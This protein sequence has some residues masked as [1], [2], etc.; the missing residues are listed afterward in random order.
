MFGVRRL[1]PFHT[2]SRKPSDRRESGYRGIFTRRSVKKHPSINTI[3]HLQRA[4][5]PR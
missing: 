2:R 1:F 3:D 4:K 5:I